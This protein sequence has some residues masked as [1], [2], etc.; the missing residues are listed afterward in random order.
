MA[1]PKEQ[2]SSERLCEAAEAALKAA[3]EIGEERG[4]DWPYPVDLMGG[5]DQPE[6]LCEFTRWEI[7]QACEFLV[8]MGMLSAPR[9]KGWFW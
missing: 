4:G 7:Q 2:L 1:R 8:R 3:A 5:A 6:C 9:R